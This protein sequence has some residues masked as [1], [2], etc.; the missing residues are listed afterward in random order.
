MATI[1]VQT[2]PPSAHLVYEAAD[3]PVGA[4]TIRVTRTCEGVTT[5]LRDGLDKPCVGGVIVDDGEMPVGADVIYEGTVHDDSYVELGTT[6]FLI[7]N[8]PTSPNDAWLSDPRDATSGVRVMLMDG[9]A[10]TLSRPTPGN[11]YQVGFTTIVLAGQT[12]LLT[13]LPMGFF[14]ETPE[15]RDAVVDLMRDTG[16]LIL[17]RTPPPFP[18]PR[19]L[20]C[21]ASNPVARTYG[22]DP[23]IAVWDN[24]VQEISE[25]PGTTQVFT[26]TW[27][28]Y[29]D[30]FPTWGDMAAAYTSWFDAAKNPPGGA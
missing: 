29:M 18:V 25:I 21:W 28:T 7:G 15:D 10:A 12:Q 19:L 27:Q 3:L 1:T 20:Y 22:S 8:V 11:R 2:D 26:V 9:A 30:A 16:G 17:I 6:D 14:T 24:T 23:D 5:T 4:A 13:D